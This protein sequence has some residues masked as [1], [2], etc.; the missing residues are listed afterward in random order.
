MDNY[1]K[2][3]EFFM[4]NGITLNKEQIEALREGFFNK[5]FSKK[6]SSNIP[7]TPVVKKSEPSHISNLSEA[8]FKEAK[9]ILDKIVKKY[10]DLLSKDKATKE[11][12]KKDIVENPNNYDSKRNVSNLPKY[13]FKVFEYGLYNNKGEITYEFSDSSNDQEDNV[14][15]L[16]CMDKGNV[17]LENMTEYKDFC[18]K[19]DVTYY[20][21]DGDEGCI[22]FQIFSK[23]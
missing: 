10:I 6:S 1:S 13:K 17:S 19:Y 11:C 5:L 21:G 2:V 3:L 23:K 14:L 16:S 12:I 7:I 9:P 18:N 15:L 22:Y 8:E 20:F 4:E